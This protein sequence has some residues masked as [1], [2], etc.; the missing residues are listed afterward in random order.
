MG[1]YSSVE[2]ETQY[3]EKSK[4]IE[5]EFGLENTKDEHT[6]ECTTP[7][8]DNQVQAASGDTGQCKKGDWMTHPAFLA[9]GG[10]GLWVGKFEAGYKGATST[11][12]ARVNSD[13]VSKL[14]VKP[15]QYSWTTI[16]VTN[17]FKV[18]RDYKSILQSHMMKNTEWGAVAYLTQSLYGKCTKAKDGSISC[19]EVS[20]N[21]NSALLTGYA[22][23]NEPTK[24]YTSTIE[25]CTDHPDDCNEY[26]S[27]KKGEDGDYNYQYF[28]PQSM[29]ASTTGNYSG[30]Y[31]MS[32]GAWEY[33]V[34]VELN[35]AGNAILYGSTASV[36]SELTDPK[37]YDIYNYGNNTRTDYSRRILGDATGEMGPLGAEISSWYKDSAIFVYSGTNAFTWFVRGGAYQYGT[38]SG[39][40]AFESQTGDVSWGNGFRVVLAC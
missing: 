9:F 7:M 39:V 4:P 32:G 29:P 36:A 12:N 1:E 14:V 3:Q 21:N 24:G 40:F 30:I 34:S 26:G 37:Y 17:A 20:I 18:A 35:K 8:L 13:D 5:I 31:D 16:Q 10:N 23:K 25:S 19:E 22:A 33:M 27:S 38:A 11:G 15:S 6:D 28:N 2:E